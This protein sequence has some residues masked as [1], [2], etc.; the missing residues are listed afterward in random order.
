MVPEVFLAASH[1][2][3]LNERTDLARG[4]V[5]EMGENFFH[6]GS[7]VVIGFFFAVSVAFGLCVL[8]SAL[9]CVAF[10]RAFR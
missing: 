5:L 6:P 8:F 2:Q 10:T 3:A 9:V 7:I 4:T 1:H